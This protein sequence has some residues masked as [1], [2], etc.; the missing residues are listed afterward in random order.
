MRMLASVAAW[1]AVLLT[2]CLVA[3]PTWGLPQETSTVDTTQQQ[4][5]EV[6]PN[7]GALDR[8]ALDRDYNPDEHDDVWLCLQDDEDRHFTCATREG[9][10]YVEQKK[11]ITYNLGHSQRIDG[12]APEKKAINDV[13]LMMRDYFH[14]EV[15]AK[16]AFKEVRHK[17]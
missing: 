17:W 11:G 2:S 8:G 12:T 5:E 16:I 3:S 14:N 13:I 1:F 7:N 6:K 15:L 9:Q 4:C 10:F